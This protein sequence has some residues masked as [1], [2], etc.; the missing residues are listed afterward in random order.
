ML[1]VEQVGSAELVELLPLQR[2]TRVEPVAGVA[3][4]GVEVVHKVLAVAPFYWTLTGVAKAQLLSIRGVEVTVALL[5]PF[6]QVPKEAQ[7]AEVSKAAKAFQGA[8]TR[9]ASTAVMMLL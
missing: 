7:A 4:A 1:L 5:D 2:A 8:R 9:I 6:D 3:R